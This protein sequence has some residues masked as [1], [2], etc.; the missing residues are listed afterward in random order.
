MCGLMHRKHIRLARKINYSMGQLFIW[1]MWIF[2]SHVTMHSYGLHSIKQRID[3]IGGALRIDSQAGKG[4][5][6]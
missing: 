6:V 3:F 5:T 4:T 2:L 1:T